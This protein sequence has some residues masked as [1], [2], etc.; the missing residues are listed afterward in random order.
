VGVGVWRLPREAAGRPCPPIGLR[1]LC[2][3]QETGRRLNP[4]FTSGTWAG[5]ASDQIKQ[6]TDTLTQAI[7]KADI[8]SGAIILID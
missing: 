4:A 3:A 7:T 2:R 1:Y 5:L 6:A 8:I